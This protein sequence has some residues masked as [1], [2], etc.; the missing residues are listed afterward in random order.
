MIKQEKMEMHSK[1]KI[2]GGKKGGDKNR[3]QKEGGVIE[4]YRERTQI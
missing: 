2:Q 3:V 4:S 1:F